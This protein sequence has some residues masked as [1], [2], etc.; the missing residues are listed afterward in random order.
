MRGLLVFLA[1]VASLPFV[2]VSPFNGILVWYAFSLGNFHRLVWGFFANIPYAFIIVIVTGLSWAISREKKQLPITPLVVLTLLFMVWI[3]ITSLF[4]AGPAAP[5]AGYADAI[6]DKWTIT[7][8][9]LLMCLVG[10]ALTTTRERVNQVI[11]VVALSIGVWGLK[12]AIWSLLHGGASRLYGPTGTAIGDNNDFGLALIVILPLL[13]YQ[14][15][16]AVN[17]YLRRGLM[18]LGFLVAAAVVFTYSRGALVG[19]CAMGTVFW[20]RSRAKLATGA[21]ILA[22]GVFAYS[23]APPQWFARMGTIETYQEDPSAMS[24]I[25]IWN[26]TLRIVEE[27][28]I[29]GGGFMMTYFPVVVNP[30]LRGTGLAELRGPLAEHSIYF[31]VLAEHGWPGLVLFLLVAAF[32]WRNCSWLVRRTRDRPEL[33]WANLLG[34][35]GQASLV[36]YWTAGAFVAQGYLDEY[37]CIIFIFDAARLLVAREITSPGSAFGTAGSTPLGVPQLGGAG[38]ALVKSDATPGYAKSRL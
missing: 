1:F 5:Y 23:F 25:H 34:R 22:V 2:F 21:L 24:R 14:W 29:V 35:M 33:A 17:P 19:L 7:E 11:W 10:F 38:A 37:W 8:K 9:K 27:H 3:T 31:E 36:A 12:G 18:V 28:P 26:I 4:A 15:Q 13:F 16:R 30:L 6:W 32:S 20:L